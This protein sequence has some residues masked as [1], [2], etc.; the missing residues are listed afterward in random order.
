MYLPCRLAN[1]CNTLYVKRNIRQTSVSR[2][3]GYDT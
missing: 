2:S 1:T 3:R